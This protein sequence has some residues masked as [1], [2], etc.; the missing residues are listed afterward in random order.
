MTD[1]KFPAHKNP[2]QRV[3][4]G[5]FVH[6]AIVQAETHQTW[7]R[8]DIQN[9]A[10]FAYYSLLDCGKFMIMYDRFHNKTMMFHNTSL[11]VPPTTAPR[12]NNATYKIL[13]KEPH[14]W[15]G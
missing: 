1:V 3:A 13:E 12:D 14:F 10:Q 9:I 4:V 7:A 15:D 2:K 5:Q 8:A 11:V 6:R